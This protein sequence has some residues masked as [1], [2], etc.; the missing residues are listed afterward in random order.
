MHS[1][2]IEVDTEKDWRTDRQ[3]EHGGSKERKQ[4]HKQKDRKKK[5]SGT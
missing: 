2:Y 4:T 3:K 1:A 5:V